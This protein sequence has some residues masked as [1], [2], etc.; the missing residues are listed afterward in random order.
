MDVFSKRKRSQIMSRIRSSGNSIE[1]V[2]RRCVKDCGYRYR[3]NDRSILGSPDVAVPSL[4]L[5]IFM[6]GCFWHGCPLHFRVP[7]TNSDFWSKKISRN[8]VRDRKIRSSLKDDGWIVWSYWEHETFDL[9]RFSR[10]L[11]R[12]IRRLKESFGRNHVT[13]LKTF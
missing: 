3:C 1:R 10:N 4:K 11:R 2:V 12:R 9:V 7:S 5:V 6:D 8:S 13:T